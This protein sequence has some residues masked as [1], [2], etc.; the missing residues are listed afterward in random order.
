MIAAVRMQRLP[1]WGPTYSTVCALH[2]LRFGLENYLIIVLF[3]ARASAGR[4]AQLDHGWHNCNS[5]TSPAP[6]HELHELASTRAA[7]VADCCR[8]E[9]WPSRYLSRPGCGDGQFRGGIRQ[10]VCLTAS[11]ILSVCLSNRLNCQ[12][13]IHNAHL[14]KRP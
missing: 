11:C 6:M 3:S 4:R 1:S 14:V 5:S 7:Y 8:F 10:H 12:L 13:A 9:A 2:E